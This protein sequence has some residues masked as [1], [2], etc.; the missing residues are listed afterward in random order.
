MGARG[1]SPP[2]PAALVSALGSP[3]G[4][5]GHA[6][7][8]QT[9]PLAPGCQPVGLGT[10]RARACADLNRLC[11]AKELNSLKL[12]LQ[13]PFLSLPFPFAPDMMAGGCSISL[14]KGLFL[15]AISTTPFCRTKKPPN[16]PSRA[17]LWRGAARIVCQRPDARWPRAGRAERGLR[18]LQM[19]RLC[20]LH[21]ANF[22]TF[23]RGSS[24]SSRRGGRAN[25]ERGFG[26]AALKR[27]PPEE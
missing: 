12:L 3:D 22:Q 5:W 15:V 24:I 26:H 17:A 18:A 2:A 8:M 27:S 23:P 16:V 13:L 11:A 20:R 1:S 19:F 14:I 10:S 7:V 25:G 6:G 4:L 9:L 21:G